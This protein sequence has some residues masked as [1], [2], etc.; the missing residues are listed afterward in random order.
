VCKDT[1]SIIHI[2]AQSESQSEMDFLDLSDIY[3]SKAAL[4]VLIYWLG[5]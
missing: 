4:V 1:W 2:P 5:S 3:I